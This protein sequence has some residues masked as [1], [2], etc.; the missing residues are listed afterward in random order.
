MLSGPLIFGQDEMERC[1][2]QALR[3]YSCD[4]VGPDDAGRAPPDETMDEGIDG[5]DGPAAAKADVKVRRTADGAP[6]A[7]KQHQGLGG[8]GGLQKTWSTF[9][10]K[11]TWSLSSLLEYSPAVKRLAPLR[12]VARAVLGTVSAMIG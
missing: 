6:V 8:R 4:D 12:L 11:K 7:V 1:S 10:L 3:R 2:R 5:T 9:S